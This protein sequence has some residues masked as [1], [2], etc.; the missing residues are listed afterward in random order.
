MTLLLITSSE[1]RNL[2]SMKTTGKRH[3]LGQVWVWKADL[4]KL[5]DDISAENIFSGSPTENKAYCTSGS[6]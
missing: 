3:G 2:W 5:E 1:Y 6:L 4:F